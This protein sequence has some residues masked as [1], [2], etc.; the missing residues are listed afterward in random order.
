M[1]KESF[2]KRYWYDVASQNRNNLRNYF[3]D[4]AVINWHNTN[5]SFTVDEFIIANCDYPG[6]WIGEVERIEMINDNAITVA[7]VRNQNNSTSCH[8]VSFFRFQGNKIIR[9]DEYWGDDD[10]PPQ[11]RLEKQIGKPIKS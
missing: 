4:D 11:W 5:E 2:L 6:K 7:R 8:V 10:L 9:I 3:K 1:D